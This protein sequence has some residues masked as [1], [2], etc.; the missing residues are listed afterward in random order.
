MTPK[1]K[2][3]D[4]L[5]NAH[6]SPRDWA[7][8]AALEPLD[9]VASELEAQW[10]CGRLERLVSPETAAKFASARK[11][12]DDAIELNEPDQVAHRAGVLI[13]GWRAMDRE[14]QLEGHSPGDPDKFWC[15]QSGSGEKYV[16][17][18]HETDTHLAAKLFPDHKA[19]SMNEL[20]RVLESAE[21]SLVARTKEVFPAATVSEVRDEPRKPV[22]WKHGDQL[23]F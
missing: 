4:P 12:L 9:K 23:P 11:K 2:P 20:A 6:G 21:W 3:A 16:I 10:G 15:V 13:K 7:M 8:A 1:L 14:A 17:V 5:L 18:Q 19:W 22:D